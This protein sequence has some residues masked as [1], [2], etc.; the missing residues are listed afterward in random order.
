MHPTLRETN[1]VDLK[2]PLVTKALTYGPSLLHQHSLPSW[3]LIGS[4]LFTWP[5][6]V[7]SAPKSEYLQ[8]LVGEAASSSLQMQSTNHGADIKP[9]LLGP[10]HMQDLPGKTAH[11]K[12]AM[13]RDEGGEMPQDATWVSGSSSAWKSTPWLFSWV[14]WTPLFCSLPPFLKPL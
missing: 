10:P 5:K 9:E 12:K 2:H 4:G 3:S 14:K 13:L 11:T 1:G 7:Q 8:V 6:S